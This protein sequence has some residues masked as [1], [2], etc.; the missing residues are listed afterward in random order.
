MKISEKARAILNDQGRLEKQAVWFQRLDDFFA[1][2]S[3]EYT[4]NYV[5]ALY[6]I[7]G[8]SEVDFHTQP[9]QWLISALENLAERIGET[10]RN[11]MFVPPCIEYDIFGVHFIDKI[12][13]ARVFFQDGQWYNDYIDTKIGQLIKPDL[14]KN[15]VWA[16]AQ[17]LLYAFLDQDVHLPLFGLPVIASALNIAVNLYGQEFL[18]AM[19]L[20]Q[21]SAAHD[22]QVINTLL[23]DIHKWYLNKLPLRTLQPTLALMRTQPY[24]YGQLCGCT[25]HLISG[26][27]YRDLVAPLDAALLG[28]YP[29]GGMIHLCGSHLQHL[30]TFRDMAALRAIQ[31]NDRAA[32]DLEDYYNGLRKDQIIYLNPCEGMTAEQAIKIT[33]GDRLIIVGDMDR[34]VLKH[35]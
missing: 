31:V 26:E 6:G 16:L 35:Q 1:G 27:A 3:N 29:N 30:N 5:L 14:E 23:C 34:A 17:R 19:M 7:N 18:I 4:D 11:Y 15:A 28:T 8:N 22:L 10:D 20:N 13:G 24:G 21:E 2:R 32:H 9:E 25:T 33:G 12:F